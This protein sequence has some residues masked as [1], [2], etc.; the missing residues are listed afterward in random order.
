MATTLNGPFRTPVSTSGT[1]DVDQQGLVRRLTARESFGQTVRDVTIPFGDFGLPV[2]VSPPP[3][4]VT[5]RP[6]A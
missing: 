2:A 3:A 5:Y 1:A 4:S 6:P